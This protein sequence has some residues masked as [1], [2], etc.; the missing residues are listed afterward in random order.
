VNWEAEKEIWDQMLFEGDASLKV[1]CDELIRVQ[2]LTDF[3][4][5]VRYKVDNVDFNRGPK[6]TASATD[7]LRSDGL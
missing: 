2:I 4:P 3:A 7:E 1:G 6:R 5:T